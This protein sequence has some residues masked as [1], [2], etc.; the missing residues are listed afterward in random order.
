MKKNVELVW[1]QRFTNHT[2]KQHEW[3]VKYSA[4]YMLHGWI[5]DLKSKL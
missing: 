2:K 5:V 3:Y 4:Q 1:N